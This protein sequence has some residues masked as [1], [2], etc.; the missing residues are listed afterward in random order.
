MICD[1]SSRLERPTH[2]G[3][4]VT[5][6]CSLTLTFALLEVYLLRREQW[7]FLSTE[8][9]I[10]AGSTGEEVPGVWREFPRDSLSHPLPSV[11]SGT[12][13][14]GFLFWFPFTI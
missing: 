9:G 13:L 3:G 6:R 5:V 8:H 1:A 14:E 7:A 4:S 11:P 10:N 12:Y 2:P